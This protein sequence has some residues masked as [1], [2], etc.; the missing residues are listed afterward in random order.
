MSLP[1]RLLPRLRPLIPS[2]TIVSAAPKRTEEWPQRMSLG[3]YYEVIL[4]S[5]SQIPI[6]KPEVPPK[7]ADPSVQSRFP[8]KTATQ[9]PEEKARLVFGSPRRL[10]GTAEKDER[11]AARKA[12][13]TYIAGVLVPPKPTEPD[14]CCMSGCVNCVYDLYRDELEEWQLKNAEAQAALRKVEGSVDSDGGGSETSWAG[15]SVGEAKIAK[16]FWDDELYAN[17]PVGIRE[18]MKTEKQLKKRH[19][20]EGAKE[21]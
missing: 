18:F 2:R 19:E 14:N 20:S 10:F 4:N 11:L 7:T 3:P 15:R 9:T 13:A 5:P 21:G 16:D 12:Q 17:L 8:T 6:D 1:S